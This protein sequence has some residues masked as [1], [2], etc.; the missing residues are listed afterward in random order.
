M[1]PGLPTEPQLGV[2]ANPEVER[3]PQDQSRRERRIQ[4]Q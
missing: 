1:H 2:E 4:S 3:G